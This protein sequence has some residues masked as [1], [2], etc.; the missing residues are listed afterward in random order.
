[1]ATAIP[2][3]PLFAF[4]D[5]TDRHAAERSDPRDAAQ[6]V[7][8]PG[9]K[10]L[11]VDDSAVARKLVEQA[12]FGQPYSLIFAST[13]QQAVELYIQHRPSFVIT[14]GLSPSSPSAIL[15][16]AAGPITWTC[17]GR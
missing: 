3:I 13:G 15:A 1:M 5:N 6:R 16:S 12:L 14:Q 7:V 11:I 2:G 17:G 10:V 8:E 4:P 9:K